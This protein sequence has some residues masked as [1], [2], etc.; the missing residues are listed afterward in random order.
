[1]NTN[2]VYGMGINTYIYTNSSRRTTE[3]DNFASKGQKNNSRIKFA[4]R[5]EDMVGTNVPPN[6]RKAYAV[7]GQD[8]YVSENIADIYGMGV[9]SRKDIS[10]AQESTQPIENGK[11]FS[12][13]ESE[14]ADSQESKSKTE[15][16]VK[17]DGSRVLVMTMNIGGMETTMSLEI[18]K[19]TNA[20]NKNSKQDTENNMPTAEA[21]RNDSVSDEVSSVTSNGN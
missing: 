15:I 3:T 19:P 16:I 18:S 11:F 4:S 8:N 6:S 5:M 13:E 12:D 9:Y 2:G 7:L 21:V 17:P 14:S 20:L 10:A 1:M